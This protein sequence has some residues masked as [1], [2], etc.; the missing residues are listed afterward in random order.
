MPSFCNVNC[1]TQVGI[2]NKLAEGALDPTVYVIDKDVEVYPIQT[3]WGIP[4]VTGLHLDIEPLTTT[5][6]L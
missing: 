2:I 3:P 4:L 5:L 6:W 1:T